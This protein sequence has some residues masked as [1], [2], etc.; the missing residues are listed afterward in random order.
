M[1][2]STG[3]KLPQKE[4]A[5]FKKVVVSVCDL[6]IACEWVM[7]VNLVD[8]EVLRMQAVQECSEVLSSDPQ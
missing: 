6:I 2:S 4:N 3:Q 1:A 5:I 8:P 7:D